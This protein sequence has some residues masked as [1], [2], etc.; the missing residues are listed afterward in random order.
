MLRTKATPE[1][2][3]G[4]AFDEAGPTPM[5]SAAFHHI[6]YGHGSIPSNWNTYQ[7]IQRPDALG[8][9]GWYTAGYFSHGAP[10]VND[11]TVMH[12]WVL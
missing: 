5:R 11:K 10:A 4:A 8:T 3:A 1:L 12:W 9:E 2:L 7:D 6:R